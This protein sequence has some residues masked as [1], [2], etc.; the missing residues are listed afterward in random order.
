MNSNILI[1]LRVIAEQGNDHF[2]RKFETENVSTVD[3]S[4]VKLI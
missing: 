4:N 2:Y 3:T 1:C